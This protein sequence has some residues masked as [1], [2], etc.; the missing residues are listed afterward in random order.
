MHRFRSALIA[1]VLIPVLVAVGALVVVLRAMDAELEGLERF[2]FASTHA[3]EAERLKAESE[4]FGRMV[5]GYLLVPDAPRQEEVRVSLERFEEALRRM[6]GLSRS[7]EERTRVEAVARAEVR[8]RT[9]SWELMERRR[10]GAPVER[11]QSR[12]IGEV[13]P[14]RVALDEALRALTLHQRAEMEAARLQAHQR[15]GGLVRVFLLGVPVAVGIL[16]SLVVLVVREV[17]QRREAQEVAERNASRLAASE[18]R[19]AGII[20]I[21]A[22]AIITIDAEQRITLFNSGASAIFGYDVAE[23]LGQPL[24][25]LIPERFWA[26]HREFVRSFAEGVPTAR[27]MGAHRP[28]FG[29]RKNGE[30]FSAEA[31]ISKLQVG[32]QWILTVIVRDVSAQKRVEEEQRFLVKAGELLSSSL[33]SERTLASVA[34][35]A[36]RSLADWCIVFLVEGEQV[37]RAEVAHRTPEKE[38]LA[39]GLRVL[40]IDMRQPFL[41]SEVLK[42]REPLL[43]PHLTEAQ[44]ASM[45]Q[46][47]EHLRLLQAL[48]P[49]SLVGVPLVA[50][51]RPL[52]ALVFI[53]SESG[54]VYDGADV[55]FA[56]GLARLAGLAV[57]NARLYQAARRATQARDEV[58]G[59]VAHDLRSPLNS[60]V[61]GV[62]TLQRQGASRAEAASEQNQEKLEKI[63]SSARRMN[64]LIEDLL[65]VA[66]MEAGKLSLSPAPQHTESLLREAVEAAQPLAGEVQLLLEEP[67]VLP[68]VLADR[69]RLL[70]VFS[71]LLGNALKFTPRGGQV[72]VG[73][74]A[75][76][77]QVCFY[78]RDTGPGLTPEAL[79]HIFDRFWQL[80][81]KDRRGAGLGLSIVKGL[82]E[83][84]GGCLRVESEPGHGSTFFFTVPVAR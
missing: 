14:A 8:L 83:A 71:N 25:L 73:A 17:R 39:A 49:R 24:E 13:M 80:D 76:G 3:L 43:V 45:S 63:L 33:D 55:E 6:A 62:Q 30:E 7:P 10:Q 41:A 81:R 75:E 37:R 20:S 58:L 31:A 50:G 52:G 9:L 46:G 70:Q 69:D 22:D 12:F 23:V 78:V 56:R 34:R 42:R 53:S 57:E 32:E 84:H 82:V 18:A 27:K 67:G 64:R 21:A 16:V 74:R 1:M 29:R 61:V 60:I 36:V 4:Q 51:E 35:L 5:R 28:I 68:P 59:I 19:F 11:I 79:A 40:P 77:E 44:L 72:R 26:S 48:Q 38:A 66:R 54:R 47:A 65:D 2:A 15:L